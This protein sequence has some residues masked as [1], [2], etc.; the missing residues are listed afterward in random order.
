[1][2]KSL[3]LS[4]LLLFSA[5]WLD[6]NRSAHKQLEKLNFD[7]AEDLLQRSLEKDSI[8]PGAWYVY[9]L[10]YSMESYPKQDYE[11]AFDYILK[12][13][14]QWDLATED[15]RDDIARNDWSLEHF[16]QQHRLLDSALFAEARGQ[17]SLKAYQHYLDRHPGAKQYTEAVTYRNQLAFAAAEQVN[18]WQA[19]RDFSEQYPGAT[20]APEALLRYQRMQFEEMTAAGTPKAYEAFVRQYPENPYTADAV[21]F[22]F[23]WNTADHNREDYK[24]F[25]KRYPQSPLVRTAIDRLYHLY[26][27]QGES[28]LFFAAFGESTQQ[29][30]SLRQIDRLNQKPLIP[31]WDNG[32][33]LA[34]AQGKVLIRLASMQIPDDSLC[35]GLRSD[36]LLGTTGGSKQLLARNGRVF[37]AG[38]A[39]A[40]TD[41]GHGLLRVTDERGTG[42]LHKNGDWLIKPRYSAIDLL[43]G[44]LVVVSKGG[45][46]GLY[47]VNEDRLLDI[48]YEEIMQEGPFILLKRQGRYAVTTTARLHRLAHH[49]GGDFRFNYDDVELFRKKYLITYDGDQEAVLNERLQNIIPPRPQELNRFGRFWTIAFEGQVQLYDE[50]ENSYS[51]GFYEQVDGNDSLLIMRQ[52]KRWYYQSVS[53]PLNP[54]GSYDSMRLLSDNLLYIADQQAGA[55]V[56]FDLRDT[57][58]LEPGEQVRVMR[59]MQQKTGGRR[60]LLSNDG[61]TR[62]LYAPDGKKILGGRFDEIRIETDFL[63]VIGEKGRKGLSDS[64]GLNILPI[65]YDAIADY[66]KGWVSLVDGSRFGA[67]RYPQQTL[68][69]PR[70]ER[71]LEVIADS[72]LVAVEEGKSGLLNPQGEIVIPFE[73]KD[74]RAWD[75]ER[76]LVQ[77][78]LNWHWYS[79]GSEM[80]L[81]DP[82]L[83]SSWV[84]DSPEEK[85]IIYRGE[86]GAGM[87]STRT[88][89]SIAPTLSDLI[90]LRS[91]KE[92]FYMGEVSVPEAEMH[93]LIYYDASGTRLFAHA[94]GKE[95]FEALYCD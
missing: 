25:I 94:V 36:V 57:L 17:H 76:F 16:K 67:F 88:Q 91:G 29:I 77:K 68:I 18:T 15:T 19:Y 10:M 28:H 27:E 38:P 47:T 72:M 84:S 54:Q 14:E 31:V 44:S 63:F 1:M 46:K 51:P 66:R 9:S 58:A 71:R 74:I 8:N 75:K 26:R 90:V 30:D 43:D 4:G 50:E 79:P 39:S 60:Y 11:Q 35:G 70:Y 12:A 42:L 64:S 22:I 33:A 48:E 21:R 41:L 83:I 6:A 2:T 61:Q 56:I 7:R 65:R 73:F 55:R 23:N 3:L 52:N 87:A 62:R 5:V 69:T 92:R 20:E 34:D 49:E 93:V 89:S 59:S 40:I 85:T 86:D 13:E 78:D 53:L 82:F 32:L 80:P 45:A 24:N 95:A 81:S 37:Y